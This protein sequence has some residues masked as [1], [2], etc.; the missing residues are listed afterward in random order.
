MTAAI[1]IAVLVACGLI[2]VAIGSH[3]AGKRRSRPLPVLDPSSNRD[4]V[5]TPVSDAAP[6]ESPVREPIEREVLPRQIFAGVTSPP[7]EAASSA[8][9]SQV[10]G[11]KDPAGFTS[12]A[13]RSP[14]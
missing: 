11:S 8:I 9:E 7:V 12:A 3:L 5:A 4:V 14:C 13:I 6:I 1:L 2:S 10:A